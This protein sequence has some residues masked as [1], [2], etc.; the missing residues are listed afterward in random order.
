MEDSFENCDFFTCSISLLHSKNGKAGNEW[1][2]T[3]RKAAI[4]GRGVWIS[5]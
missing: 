3:K 2:L 5:Y 4:E 1:V